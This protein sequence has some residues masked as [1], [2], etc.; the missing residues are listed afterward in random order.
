MKRIV[1]W[2]AGIGVCVLLAAGAAVAQEKPGVSGVTN[3]L[4]L[5]GVQRNAKG[6][7]LVEGNSLRFVSSKGKAEVPLAQ[8]QDVLTGDDSQR[9]VRGTLQTLS[10]FAPYGGGRFLS[11]F[12]TKVDLLTLEY[13]DASGAL[14][15]VVLTLPNGKAVVIKK[16]M[17]E[18]GAKSSVPIEEDMKKEEEKKDKKTEKKQ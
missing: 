18:A 1:R 6:T 7:L 12:R 17:V 8:V 4:G 15:G 3:V 13:R 5:E 10:M 14:H 2:C 11:L 9:V 16:Q